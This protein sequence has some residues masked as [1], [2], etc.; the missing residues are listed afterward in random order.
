MFEQVDV[1]DKIPMPYEN[2]TE[3]ADSFFGL[4]EPT[5]YSTLFVKQPDFSAIKHINHEIY[6]K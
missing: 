5:I 4:V 3:K 1:E 6:D 2:S